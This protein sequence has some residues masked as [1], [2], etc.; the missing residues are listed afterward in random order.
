MYERYNIFSPEGINTLVRHSPTVFDAHSIRS[1]RV[2]PC[3]ALGKSAG[4]RVYDA[5]WIAKKRIVD[6]ASVERWAGRCGRRVSMVELAD[7]I[8]D[9]I[10]DGHCTIRRR[11]AEL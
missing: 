1:F 6:L 3:R 10:I 4:E 2:A 5:D 9:D 11:W 8:I 7:A